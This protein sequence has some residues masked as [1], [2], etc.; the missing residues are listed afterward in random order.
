MDLECDGEL[1]FELLDPVQGLLELVLLRLQQRC[2]LRY[3][4]AV[5]VVRIDENGFG[6]RVWG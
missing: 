4:P 3:L 2:H 6:F 5:S 1:V